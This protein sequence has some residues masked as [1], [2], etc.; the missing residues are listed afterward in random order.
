MRWL[1]A[2]VVAG[3]GSSDGG[4]TPDASGAPD[5]TDAAPDATPDAAVPPG[6]PSL[7]TTSISLGLVRIGDQETA[8]ITVTN[9]S[10]LSSA[11]LDQITV[12]GTG[13]AMVTSCGQALPPAGTCTIDIAFAPLERGL[14]E[15]TL[16]VVS[17]G[18]SQA[19]SLAGT[20]AWRLALERTGVGS[21]S[22]TSTPA[23]IA[24]GTTCTG[25]FTGGV[26]LEVVPVAGSRVASWSSPGCA[27]L[28]CTVAGSVTSRD[29]TVSFAAAS[30]R[31]IYVAPSDRGT[32]T[33]SPA[34]I[35]CGTTCADVIAGDVTLTATPKPSYRVTGWSIPGCSGTTCVIPAGTTRIDVAATYGG[36]G[37]LEIVVAGDAPGEVVVW[38]DDTQLGRCT[39]S[40]SL[41]VGPG[42]VTVAAATPNRLESLAGQD[43]TVEADRCTIAVVDE[44]R[45]TATFRRDPKDRWTFFGT[46]GEVFTQGGFDQAGNLIA[47]SQHRVVKLSATG[48]LLWQKPPTYR[49][50]VGAD[51]ASYL[52]DARGTVK[53]DP[54]GNEV[55]VRPGGPNALDHSGNLLVVHAQQMTLTGPMALR[56][57]PHPVT[58]VTSAAMASSMTRSRDRRWT[59]KK[60]TLTSCCTRTATGPPARRCLTRGAGVRSSWEDRSS[61]WRPRTARRPSSATAMTTRC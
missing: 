12:A 58:A 38:R 15:G 27:G 7:S 53:Y 26:D 60:I 54:D 2:V 42:P 49:F 37:I 9:T 34:G 47:G 30:G 35:D 40:C 16:M 36:I 51:G 55:W 3:C 18:V 22:I 17:A 45:L 4:L 1:L 19:A 48:Q 43:C 21:G 33:S 13:Y 61:L 5:A 24:C 14:H 10:A 23:G 56:C 44:A 29:V 8:R 32:V 52:G 20:G 39:A 59:P 50:L 31:A 11:P 25:L 6:T 28:R 46:S 41:V 57:G